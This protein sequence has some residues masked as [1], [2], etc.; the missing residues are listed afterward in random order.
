[1]LCWLSLPVA[2]AT[3]GGLKSFIGVTVKV[4]GLE[5]PACWSS[6]TT[7]E[8]GCPWVSAAVLWLPLGVG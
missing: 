2:E 6:M 7:K 5:D 4:S 8:V 3:D 1:M